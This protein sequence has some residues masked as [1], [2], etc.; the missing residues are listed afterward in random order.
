[1]T[2]NVR[3]EENL[4]R[5]RLL[6][7]PIRNRQKMVTLLADLLK[8]VNRD[9]SSATWTE[10]SEGDQLIEIIYKDCEIN[11]QWMACRCEVWQRPDNTT[12]ELCYPA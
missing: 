1:M 6:N 7:P 3:R 9:T 11:G 8:F 12:Y 10:D 5:I 2:D 4:L